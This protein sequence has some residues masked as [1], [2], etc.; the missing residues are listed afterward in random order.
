MK[1]YNEKCTTIPILHFFP[2]R[3]FYDSYILTILTIHRIFTK[4]LPI[5]NLFDPCF[6]SGVV[7]FGC[8]LTEK[9]FTIAFRERKE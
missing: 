2:V 8:G 9:I 3:I 1:Q 4:V 6:S 7:L 5:D